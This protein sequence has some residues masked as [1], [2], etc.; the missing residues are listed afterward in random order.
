MIINIALTTTQ[1]AITTNGP[2]NYKW[3]M[4]EASRKERKIV[5]EGA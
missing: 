1:T 2:N 4:K 3:G 5:K